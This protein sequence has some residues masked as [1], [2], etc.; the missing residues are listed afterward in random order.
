[1]LKRL[2]A[3]H[4][5]SLSVE[6][7]WNCLIGDFRILFDDGSEI[8]TN[9]RETLYSAYAW[10]LLRAYPETP[11]LSHHHVH[12]IA[13]KSKFTSRTHIDLLGYIYWDIADHYKL[14][15]PESRDHLTKLV[16]EATNHMFNDL[17]QRC[18]SFVASIDIMDFI[19]ITKHPKVKDVLD[20]PRHTREY[21]ESTHELMMEFVN[22]DPDIENNSLARASRYGTVNANQVL[23][24]VGPRGYL[25]E[26][27]SVILPVP[28]VRSFTKGMRSIYNLAAESRSAAKSL[29]FSD[30]QLKDAEYFARKL[31]LLTMT[32]ERLHHVDCGSTDYVNWRVKPPVVE[33]GETIYPGDLKFLVGKY[34]LDPETNE[35]KVI[36]KNDKHLYNKSIKMRSVLTCQHPD[37]AGVCAVCFGRMADN[38]MPGANI[39]H[40]CA[41]TMTQQTTQSVLSIK[42]LD[43]S[44]LAEPIALNEISRKYFNVTKDGVGFILK[45]ELKKEQVKLIVAQDEAFGLTDLDIIVKVEDLNPTRVTKLEAIILELP[46]RGLNETIIVSQ[47]CRSPSLSMD[48]LKYLKVHGWTSINKNQ[49][50][51]NCF[52][53]DLSGWDF[54]KPILRMPEMEYSFSQNSAQIA[55][56]IE[57]KIKDISDRMKP[58]S[59]MHTL[60]ELFDLVNSKLNVNIALLEIIVYGSMIRNGADNDHSLARFSDYASMGTA[61]IT[62]RSR[63]LSAGYAYENQ[64]DIIMNPM[65]FFKLNR[66]DSVFDVFIEPKDVVDYWKNR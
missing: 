23:Q 47:K 18:E 4:L 65:S 48:F 3:R 13:L 63:S 43:M 33:E 44:A 31:Q 22:K 36:T 8:T 35:L 58:E 5:L 27:D 16:Y 14:Y 21:I 56:I 59:P 24:C 39:G 37:V 57:S 30:T 19:S 54:N 9:Y 41:A 49:K 45:P 29:Y 52:L 40:L 12:H 20:N 17:Q 25:T 32:V 62:M 51:G 28:V 53:F 26:V 34:Y 15:T 46:K 60:T 1:M 2:S 64:A 10:D 66:P 38:V 7:L 11:I 50:N 42:H 61:K 6:Q 55:E